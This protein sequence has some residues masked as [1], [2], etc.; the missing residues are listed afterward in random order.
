M[1]APALISTTRVPTNLAHN[2]VETWILRL[3]N[4]QLL[5]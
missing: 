5:K 3:L 1:L 4:S 2:V